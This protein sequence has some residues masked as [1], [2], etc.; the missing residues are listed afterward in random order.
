MNEWHRISI[1]YWYVNGRRWFTKKQLVVQIIQS[2]AIK[3]LQKKKRV[4]QDDVIKNMSVKS[5]TVKQF[6]KH[7]ENMMFLFCLLIIVNDF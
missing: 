3:P 7:D 1:H 6:R 5:Q 2:D 4:Q